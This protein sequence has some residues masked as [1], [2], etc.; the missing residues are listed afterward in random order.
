M[1]KLRGLRAPG[2]R[3]KCESA[4][5]SVAGMM[6]PSLRRRELAAVVVLM[7]LASAALAFAA[8]RIAR[9]RS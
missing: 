1:P 6:E 5:A 3:A 8:P 7:A 9:P 4:S 2:T